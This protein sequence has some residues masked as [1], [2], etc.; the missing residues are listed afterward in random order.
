MG[1]AW[2]YFTM[3]NMVH[4]HGPVT[5]VLEFFLLIFLLILAIVICI[6]LYC[7]HCAGNWCCSVTGGSISLIMR[8]IHHPYT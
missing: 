6:D 1:F 7:S 8:N 5:V 2:H 4:H 3:W